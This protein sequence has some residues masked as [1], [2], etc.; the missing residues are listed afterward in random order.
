MNFGGLYGRFLLQ[1][2]RRRLSK[3]G[4]IF[5]TLFVTARCN[6]RCGHC[7]YRGQLEA[8]GG[9]GELTLDE[10]RQVS[11]QM[12]PFT[13]LLLSGGE[14]FLRRDLARVVSVFCEGNGV[15]Q[16]TIP[17]NGTLPGPTEAAADELT[18]RF[19]RVSFELQ[20]S[21]DGVGADHDRLR[22]LPGA[23]E[24]LLETH[25]GL[26]RL[27]KRRPN[28][29]VTF[30]FTLSA[31]SHGH[32]EQVCRFLEHELR[33]RVMHVVLIRGCPHDEDSS[34]I[35]PAQVRA[36]MDRARA[37]AGAGAGRRPLSWRL[38]RPLLEAR[39]DI[40]M[41]LIE[42]GMALGR[43]PLPTCLAGTLN[44]VIDEQGKVYT[45]ELRPDPAGD[46]R[47]LGY[48]FK[49]IWRG[50][51]MDQARQAIAAQRCTCTCETNVSTNLWFDL[52]SLPQLALTTARRVLGR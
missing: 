26:A 38:L 45:C 36:A 27:A 13:K 5:V 28:L 44:A 19:P 7:F 46:L 22:G 50:A 52:T 10:Y 42:Q 35:T 3:R 41:M 12:P 4:P 51:H 17:T 47:Q 29:D 48:D 43:R 32:M 14:P 1:G 49:A 21:I 24:L 25:R 39:K 23:F 2:W 15:G 18:A 33:S 16:V 9:E 31:H 8:T 6:A 37:M 34:H 11:A 20:L 30:C 40:S